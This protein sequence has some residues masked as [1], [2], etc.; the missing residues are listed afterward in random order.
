MP[1]TVSN[2]KKC[3]T[4]AYK[5]PRKYCRPI[6]KRRF[7]RTGK[8]TYRKK[9]MDDL[10]RVAA[11]FWD[12]DT[13]LVEEIS[14][15][16]PFDLASSDDLIDG[17]KWPHSSSVTANSN[18]KI[19]CGQYQPFKFPYSASQTP[20]SGS[21]TIDKEKL[22]KYQYI[23]LVKT[24]VIFERLPG[25]ETST[26]YNNLNHQVT[27]SPPYKGFLLSDVTQRYQPV[28]TASSGYAR[29]DVPEHPRKY[30]LDSRRTQ[31]FTYNYLRESPEIYNR[32][33]DTNDVLA[34]NLDTTLI[35]YQTHAYKIHSVPWSSL[36]DNASSAFRIHI[37]R[38]F[39][40]CRRKKAIINESFG[41]Q[42]LAH[43]T[44]PPS[45][46]DIDQIMTPQLGAMIRKA[47]GFATGQL[48]TMLMNQLRTMGRDAIRDM[49][50]NIGIK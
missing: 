3:T 50:R 8:G 19:F 16:Q 2:I 12:K 41:T 22:L 1:R 48:G 4:I 11:S 32:W 23:R 49:I 43:I 40:F 25:I 17:A 26:A 6:C 33:Y 13:Q 39:E 9:R 27:S 34:N 36:I 29:F 46:E 15:L 45:K 31:T 35:K 30:R 20:D 14:Y 37:K 21:G 28:N 7:R 44:D 38:Q 47:T 42:A 10:K 24:E 18:D 5:R